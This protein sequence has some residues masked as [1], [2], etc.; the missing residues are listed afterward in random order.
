MTG[1]VVIYY[2]SRKIESRE[3]R[4]GICRPGVQY[5]K[6]HVQQGADKRAAG[7]LE[8]VISP[9]IYFV[10]LHKKYAENFCRNTEFLLDIRAITWY[11]K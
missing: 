6:E 2:N 9:K 4:S 10:Y 11:I 5:V 1:V 7:E 8:G 3:H